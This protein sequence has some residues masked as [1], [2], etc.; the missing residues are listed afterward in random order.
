[1]RRSVRTLFGSVSP[2]TKFIMNGSM[3]NRKQG[4][5]VKYRWSG[6]LENGEQK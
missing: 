6:L 3:P 1:M 5:L 4:A 2:K